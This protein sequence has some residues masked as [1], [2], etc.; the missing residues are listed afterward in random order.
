MR[1]WWVNH[2]MTFKAESEGGFIW[3]PTRT[4][5]GHRKETWDNLKLVAKGDMV[6]SYAQ[7][8]ICAVG[9]ATAEP[10]P[11]KRPKY[12][13]EG[14]QNWNPD[15]VYVPIAWAPLETRLSPSN[16][17]AQIR[18]L[19]PKKN[20]PIRAENGHG[21]QSCYL[22][23]IS[24]ELADRL[25]QL[26]E[27]TDLS[28]GSL[29]PDALESRAEDQAEE[30]IRRAPLSETMKRQLVLARRGHGQFRADVLKRGQS[31]CRVTG[32]SGAALLTASHIKPWRVADN[33]ERLDPHN[34]LLLSPHIDRLFDRGLV[35]F[36]VDGSVMLANSAA[37]TAWK[38]W[39]LSN[40]LRISAMSKREALFMEY[41][42]DQI[43]KR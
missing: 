42:R 1:H 10:T 30:E 43:F 36:A 41:H 21:N 16:E 34:G 38:A 4:Q 5:A 37:S 18:D 9:L 33:E 3:A 13:A 32:V 11:R 6:F 24:K 26:I 7:Q 40:D 12:R 31:T 17:I 27:R 35:S 15:G 29:L 8:H 19:L 28:G 22:A 25:L 39:G 20:S 23:S 14:A 2:N